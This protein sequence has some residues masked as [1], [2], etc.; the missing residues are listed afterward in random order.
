[1]KLPMPVFLCVHEAASDR[2]YF[3]DIKRHVRRHYLAFVRRKTIAFPLDDVF[4]LSEETGVWWLIRLFNMESDF[5]AFAKSLL[6]LLAHKKSFDMHN[7]RRQRC[8]PAQ[9]TADEDIAVM[10]SFLNACRTVSGY[11]L[12]DWKGPTVNSIWELEGERFFDHQMQEGTLAWAYQQLAGPYHDIL[13]KGRK[14]VTELERPY[15]LFRDPLLVRGCYSAEQRA[16][17][18]RRRQSLP[19]RFGARGGGV[20]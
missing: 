7:E 20:G 11:L 13:A 12:E 16:E 10:M 15:W 18:E 9:E 2:V 8:D 1:M 4:C 17:M 3:L 14:L 5:E 6:F 19:M